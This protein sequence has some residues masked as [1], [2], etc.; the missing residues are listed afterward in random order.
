MK[1]S[2]P[3]TLTDTERLNFFVQTG[4]AW[5]RDVYRT[6]GKLLWN[7]VEQVTVTHGQSLREAIDSAVAYFKFQGGE[8]REPYASGTPPRVASECVIIYGPQACGK[9]TNAPRFAR[10]YGGH[11]MDFGSFDFRIDK[12]VAV[13]FAD[14]I[15]NANR[16]VRYCKKNCFITPRIVTFEDALKESAQ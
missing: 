2:I 7:S 15:E 5:T 14:S 1:K 12:G 8:I 11:C 4:A 3:S 9:T 16:A 6:S 10:H 13:L